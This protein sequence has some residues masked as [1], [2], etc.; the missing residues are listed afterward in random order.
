MPA[1]AL[2]L[3]MLRVD[4]VID[5]FMPASECAFNIF[6]GSEKAICVDD[7]P[8]VAGEV[9]KRTSH[10]LII[11]LI[12]LHVRISV[13]AAVNCQP[14]N[15]VILPVRATLNA[16]RAAIWIQGKSVILGTVPHLKSILI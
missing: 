4:E 12:L 9:I 14:V 3:D 2:G 15:Q 8:I 13:A 1:M 16:L 5:L 11:R 7:A 6:I 10:L